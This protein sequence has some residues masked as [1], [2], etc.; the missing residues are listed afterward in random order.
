M[1]T[2]RKVVSYGDLQHA[3][4]STAKTTGTMRRQVTTS[5]V[6]IIVAVLDER[7]WNAASEIIQE[8]VEA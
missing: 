7:A 5:L 1:A 6:P 2:V 4:E 8:K 3:C